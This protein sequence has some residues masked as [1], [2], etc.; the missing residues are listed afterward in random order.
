MTDVFTKLSHMDYEG[1]YEDAEFI[2]QNPMTYTAKTVLG[3]A[4]KPIVS[5]MVPA[6]VRDVAQMLDPYTKNAA[7]VPGTWGYLN[8]LAA[9][10]PGLG[11]DLPGTYNI[12]GEDVRADAGSPVGTFFHFHKV[13]KTFTPQIQL[14]KDVGADIRPTPYRAE[15]VKLHPV[16]RS[17][18]AR[19]TGRRFVK[20][21]ITQMHSPGFAGASNF[22][23]RMQI[24]L[25]HR[26]ATA[27]AKMYLRQNIPA[28]DQRVT[29]HQR[30]EMITMQQGISGRGGASPKFQ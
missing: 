23:K 5:N 6:L 9:R 4:T 8:G 13:S 1:L 25:M 29:D 18:M 19:E 16:E 2:G 11:K 10:T 14:I 28:F 20:R 22:S 30:Y 26:D 12:V 7:A 27:E 15:G 3:K 17:L 21:L 24:E